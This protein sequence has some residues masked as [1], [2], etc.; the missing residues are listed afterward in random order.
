MLLEANVYRVLGYAHSVN[1][2]SEPFTVVKYEGRSLIL[3]CLTAYWAIKFGYF[4][5]VIK[6]ANKL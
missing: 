6:N 3:A 2:N 1:A 4:R 5:V